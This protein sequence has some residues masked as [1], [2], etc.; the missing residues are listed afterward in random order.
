MI[1][2]HQGM[3]IEQVLKTSLERE[4]QAYEFY[5]RL[6]AD[7]SVDCVRELLLKL[8][9]E[10]SK[11]QLMIQKMLTRLEVGKDLLS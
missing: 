2:T 9:N 11:H 1:A 7:C 8:K 4:R 5:N 10:E 6:A 3:T